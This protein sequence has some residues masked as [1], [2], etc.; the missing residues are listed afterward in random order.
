MATLPEASDL[1]REAAAA[2]DVAQ[3]VLRWDY[4]FSP[5][6]TTA[7]MNS[8]IQGYGHHQLVWENGR[9]TSYGPA[10]SRSR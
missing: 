9:R 5:E 10:A 1:V 8:Q 3:Y 2:G 6:G 7:C 4:V